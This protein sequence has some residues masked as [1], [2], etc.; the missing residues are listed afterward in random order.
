MEGDRP[1]EASEYRTDRL[2]DVR[3]KLAVASAIVVAVAALLLVVLL[4]A[5]VFQPASNTNPCESPDGCPYAPTFELGPAVEKG[6]PGAYWYNFS[7][8]G[9]CC[10]LTLGELMFEVQTQTGQ[11]L[12]LENA[13]IIVQST[14][15]H[16]SVVATYS[17]ATSE[18]TSGGSTLM[19]NQ[20]VIDLLCSN[21]LRSQGDVLVVLG[22]GGSGFT[23]SVTVSIP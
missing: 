5:W 4:E 11:V 15:P 8:Q 20:Q 3:W 22:N 17:V 19:S 14:A 10:G 18:W 9:S 2:P 23:G 1:S 21:D 7:V 12:A 16:T 13:S 6:G